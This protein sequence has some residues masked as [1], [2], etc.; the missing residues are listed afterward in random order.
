MKSLQE[1]K[2]KSQL[3]KKKKWHDNIVLLRKSKLNAIE[4]L[5]SKSLIDSYISHDDFV[6]I[7]N[8]LREH[9]DMKQEI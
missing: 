6:S 1:L 4:V 3:L 7:N 2:S 8:V 5:I 9:H